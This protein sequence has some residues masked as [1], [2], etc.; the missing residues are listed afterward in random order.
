M[1]IIYHDGGKVVEVSP[2][3]SAS[4]AKI[5]ALTIA[6]YLMALA[7][8]YP[9]EVLVWCHVSIKEQLNLSEIKTLFHHR[10]LLVSYHPAGL[11]YLGTSIGYVDDSPFVKINNKVTF[12]TWQMSSWVGGVYAEVLLAFNNKIPL[13]QDFDYFLNSIA[14]LGMRK[15]LLCY[16]EPRLLVQ[17]VQLLP[18]KNNRFR[19]FRFVKQHYKTQWVFLLLFNMLVYERKLPLL[20]FLFSFFYKSR[21]QLTI[22]LDQIAVESAKKLVNKG[23]IDVVIPTIGRKDYLYQFLIDLKAQT[24]L[25]TSIIIIEQNSD[26]ESE[27][28]LDYLSTEEW[29]FA[30]KHTFT[31][32]TGVC[33]A[34]N[35]AL[36]QITSEWVFMAD[37]DIRIESDFIKKTFEK[38][39]AYS[40]QA[41]TLKCSK[42]GEKATPAAIV[43]WNS[44][45]AGCSFVF[46]ESLKNCKF[47]MGFEF[48]FGEDG[49][50]GMQLRKQGVDILYFS[51]PEIL[52]LKAPIGGFRTKQLQLWQNDTIQPKPAPTIMLYQI[53]HNASTQTNSY[54]TNLFFKYYKFQGIRNPITYFI[55]YKKQWSLSVFWANELK[56]QNEV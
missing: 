27:S 20:P 55:H 32:Q 1:L 29:P 9:D 41:V 12:P 5:N 25:P 26:K 46:A 4:S 7:Q 31:H 56:K 51:E 50:F 8:E 54:K 45:G 28:E 53:S 42:K 14:K 43:Q 44:F 52:H 48:G 22:N 47:R 38:I 18:T 24:H 30:V 40:P 17:K 39:T 23:T 2:A 11:H 35:I 19:L 33:N 49:D 10:K 16:S 6:E 21:T 36:E 13:D 37:D 34:R 3:V 15:G